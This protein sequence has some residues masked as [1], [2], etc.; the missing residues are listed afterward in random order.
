MCVVEGLPNTAKN[1]SIRSK[2]KQVN[3]IPIY[4]YTIYSSIF[5]IQCTTLF[6]IEPI[7]HSLFVFNL[8]MCNWI[9]KHQNT[10]CI[11]L[12][13]VILNNIEKWKHGWSVYQTLFKYVVRNDC[14]VNNTFKSDFM[15]VNLNLTNIR[16][17]FYVLWIW[18][19]EI[20]FYIPYFVYSVQC[21]MHII[22]NNVMFK[23]FRY[24]NQ[25]WVNVMSMRSWM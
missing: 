22:C 6:S 25:T 20:Q 7:N 15:A 10:K 4:T 2:S 1:E 8:Q 11:V 23:G 19:N 16:N 3:K 14:N 24:R 17:W 13:Y 9:S 12:L 5:Q 18:V 21:S